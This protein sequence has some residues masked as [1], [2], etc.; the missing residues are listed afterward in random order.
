MSNS[1]NSVADLMNSL[2]QNIRDIRETIAINNQ[3][4][5]AQEKFVQNIIGYLEALTTYESD[6][7]KQLL[8]AQYNKDMSLTQGERQQYDDI[9]N[10]LYNQIVEYN[11]QI[12]SIRSELQNTTPQNV[13][14]K[15]K[16]V[17][18]LFIKA[19]S[20]TTPP[21][22]STT[23]MS[24]Y[25]SPPTSSPQMSS[26]YSTPRPT[27]QTSSYYSTPRPTPQLF[28]PQKPEEKKPEEKKTGIFETLLGSTRGDIKSTGNRSII[29]KFNPNTNTSS[30]KE[31]SFI[32]GL[33][34]HIVTV[35]DKGSFVPRPSSFPSLRNPF[36]SKKTQGGKHRRKMASRKKKI[37]RTKTQRKR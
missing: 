30:V 21:T 17:E 16:Y 2:S 35:D 12:N 1:Q 7:Q 14:S 9:I 28:I 19:L 31:S 27:S 6:W 18:D 10:M 22:S 29:A 24:S 26:Y 15:L 33:G 5:I 34:K 20:L 23:P 13:T 3:H 8:Q 32:P 11:A 37:T 25:Y 4:Y 36:Y